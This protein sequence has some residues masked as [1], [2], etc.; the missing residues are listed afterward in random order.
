MYDHPSLKVIAAN[1]DHLPAMKTRAARSV[2]ESDIEQL[3]H[4]CGYSTVEQVESLV[5]N[6]FPD[7]GL[8]ERQKQW[9]GAVIDRLTNQ[10]D[11][12]PPG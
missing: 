2:D 5:Q 10:E 1:N 9:L 7:E 12:E 6:V 3:L 4:E 8:G 11:I